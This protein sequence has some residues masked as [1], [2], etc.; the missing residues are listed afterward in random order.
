M[1]YVAT[2]LGHKWDVE[3]EE[4]ADVQQPFAKVFPNNG[5]AAVLRERLVQ[6]FWRGLV[7]SCLMLGFIM[8]FN[9]YACTCTIYSNLKKP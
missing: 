6:R 8:K 5:T 2:Q 1:C 9:N 4:E 3:T 7:L